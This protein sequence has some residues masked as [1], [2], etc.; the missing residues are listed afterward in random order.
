[1]LAGAVS[2]CDEQRPRGQYDDHAD[3][4]PLHAGVFLSSQSPAA[5][6]ARTMPA[7]MATMRPTGRLRLSL[8]S[9]LVTEPVTTSPD[10]GEGEGARTVGLGDG[11]GEAVGE[12]FGE[13]DGEGAIGG[14]DGDG[15]GGGVGEAASTTV[16][17]PVMVS[18]RRHE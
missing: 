1:M 12:G 15:L 7:T 3:D 16:T 18:W 13:G 5:L 6:P 10:F 14:G 17:V 11:E 2:R 8:R 4:E 9:M